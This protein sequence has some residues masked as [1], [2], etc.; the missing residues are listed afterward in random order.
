MSLLVTEH[1]FFE[2]PSLG[3]SAVFVLSG[4]PSGSSLGQPTCGVFGIEASTCLGGSVSSVLSVPKSAGIVDEMML[5]CK[6]EMSMVADGLNSFAA[7]VTY[8]LIKG[9]N[10]TAWNWHRN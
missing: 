6:K 2:S 3:N 5:N 9:S 10:L 8:H 7:S 1:L 4:V